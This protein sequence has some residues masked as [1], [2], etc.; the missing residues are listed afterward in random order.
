[1]KGISL[2]IVP[3][4][5]VNADGTPGERN[6]ARCA[7]IE[8]K[9]GIHASPTA[10]HRC[11]TD[12]AV[13]YLVGEENRGLEYMF[14]MMNAARFAVGLEGVAIAERAF[15]RALAYAQGARAGHG[16]RS[17]RRRSRCRSST[18]PTCAAC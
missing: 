2:F 13:G 4:F 5:L 1:M 10:V 17:A 3:K 15:Q 14:I 9:L 18:T 16:P 7:S 6:D 11:S 12:G 8:H